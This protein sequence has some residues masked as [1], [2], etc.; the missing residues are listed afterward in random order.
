[1]HLLA[2]ELEGRR[3]AVRLAEVDRVLRAVSLCP[4]P[5]SP[6]LL[7]GALNVHGRMVPVVDVRARFSL[8]SRPPEVDDRVILGRGR[9]RVMAFLVDSVEGV[10]ELP[11]DEVQ[12]AAGLL[13][14][15]ETPIEGFGQLNDGTVLVYSLNNLFSDEELTSV[16][17]AVAGWEEA[18]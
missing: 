8:P 14:R 15:F 10:V 3:F 17:E 7:Q 4:I 16:E 11:Q 13:P 1:M 2:F 12:D 6:P 18:S 9:D 5:D